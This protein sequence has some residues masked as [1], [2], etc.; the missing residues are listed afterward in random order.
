MRSVAV[1]SGTLACT[2]VTAVIAAPTALGEI[3]S[4]QPRRSI[5]PCSLLTTAQAATIMGTQPSSDGF[6]DNAGCSWQTDP[7][8]RVNLA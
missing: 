2:L 6:P 4:D 5:N 3:R 7:S 8:D 1:L